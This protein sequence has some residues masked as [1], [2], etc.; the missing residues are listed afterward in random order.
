MTNEVLRIVNTVLVSRYR[1]SLTYYYCYMYCRC[2]YYTE[3][4][5]TPS[6]TNVIHMF[7]HLVPIGEAPL[8]EN[9]VV[10]LEYVCVW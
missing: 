7:A 5:G 10:G 2:W 1:C 4:H 8:E 9:S 6:Y 3:S